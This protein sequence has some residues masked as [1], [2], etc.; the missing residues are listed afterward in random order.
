MLQKQ[1]GGQCS[2]GGP[3]EEGSSWPQLVRPCGP[4]RT[5]AFLRMSWE[6]W[7]HLRQING[8]VYYNSILVPMFLRQVDE[9][10]GCDSHPGKMKTVSMA[11]Q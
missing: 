7:V 2:W 8:F 6:P 9:H 1:Q 4:E 5:L 11:E 10:T 3:S